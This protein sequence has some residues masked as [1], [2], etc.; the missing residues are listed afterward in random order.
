[1]MPE[2]IRKALEF[3]KIR[4]YFE[5]ADPSCRVRRSSDPSS[6]YV[7]LVFNHDTDGSM[8]QRELRVPLDQ[9]FSDLV[10]LFVLL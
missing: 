1:M 6:Y 2:R 10:L 5:N 4:L 8:G 9:R 7:N 3:W